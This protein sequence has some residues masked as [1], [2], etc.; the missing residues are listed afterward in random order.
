MELITF[1]FEQSAVRVVTL[2]GE[3][4]FVAA[5]VAAILGY[6]RAHDMTRNLDDDERCVSRLK[7]AQNVPTLGGDQEH[8]IISESGLYNAIFRSRRDEARAFRRWVTGTV[9]P[10]LRRTGGF[11][12]A[13]ATIMLDDVDPTR[14][15]LALSAVALMRRLRGTAAA[16][17]LWDR[18]GLPSP[19]MVDMADGLPARIAA[20]VDGRDRFTADELATG[21]G[22][23]R[24]DQHLRQRLG[25]ALRLLGFERRRMRRGQGLIWGLSRQL[26]CVA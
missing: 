15:S 6:E 17:A 22:L 2:D 4:W 23:A 18:L 14:F 5:D 21:L 3:P 10:E 25:D 11:A 9:L 7:G 13:P 24:P 1:D 26:E 8:S 20:W 19:D 12:M 16:S